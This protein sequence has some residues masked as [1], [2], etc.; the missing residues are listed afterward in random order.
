[1][2]SGTETMFLLPYAAILKHKKATYLCIVTAFRPE[3]K[4]PRRVRFT[5]GGDRIDCAGDVSTNTADLPTV[6]LVLNSIISTPDA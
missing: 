5:I 2:K 1:M 4:N 6:K 3:K